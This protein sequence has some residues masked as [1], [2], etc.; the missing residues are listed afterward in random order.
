MTQVKEPQ[1][2][3]N[4]LRMPLTSE[5]T[6]FRLDEL[7]NRADQRDRH[8]ASNRSTFSIALDIDAPILEPV[9]RAKFPQLDQVSQ[10]TSNYRAPATRFIRATVDDSALQAALFDLDSIVEEAGEEGFPVPSTEARNQAARILR[11]IY[12]LYPRR[13]E[14]YPTADGEVAIDAR[15]PTARRSVLILCNS[16]GGAL[17]LVNLNGNHRRAVY[18][19]ASTLPDGFTRE[20]L[21]D[22]YR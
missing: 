16:G 5:V 8:P 10:W 11:A 21:A 13:F 17:C 2:S 7:F 18:D 1:C 6:S 20:A 19:S 3:A 14:V 22:V 15:S 4:L 9:G 12:P